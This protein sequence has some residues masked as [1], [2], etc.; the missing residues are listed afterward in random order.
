M[1]HVVNVLWVQRQLISFAL[2]SPAYSTTIRYVRKPAPDLSARSSRRDPLPE[3]FAAQLPTLVKSPPSGPQWIHEIKYDGYRIG[4]RIK[5]SIVNLFT[6]NGNDWTSAF[7]EIA[8][9]MK[10]LP[11]KEALIDG[12]AAVLLHDGTTS[13]Q[14][15]QGA[16]RHQRGRLV[17]FAFDLLHLDGRNLSRLP[18]E[19]RKAIL[20]RIIDKLPATDAVIHYSLHFDEDG[21]GVLRE[22]CPMGLEGIVSKQRDLPYETGRNRSWLKTKCVKRQ[23]F[24]IGGFTDPEGS[25]VGIGALLVGVNQGGHLRFAGKVGT[26]FSSDLLTEIHRRLKALERKESPFSPK[27]AGWLGRNAHW[28]KPELVAEVEFTEWTEDRKIRHPS[29]QGLREDKPASEIIRENPTQCRTNALSL[30]PPKRARGRKS[31]HL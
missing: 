1:N 2:N 4:A 16:M 17:Y 25:R 14:A 20:R 22:A 9:A 13:F 24:V 3:T 31:L 8:A 28:V 30:S 26:G 15:L 27:P 21:A 19:G 18:L 6:R 12:E 29:F 23:E 11:V 10:E 7:P 5:L